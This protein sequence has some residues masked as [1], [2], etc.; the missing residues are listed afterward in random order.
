MRLKSIFGQISS[1]ISLYHFRLL[2][3]FDLK[4]PSSPFKDLDKFLK[5][6][7][8]ISF[9]LTV[10]HGK[11]ALEHVIR[12]QKT[13]DRK[14]T[15]KIN[16]FYSSQEN[17]LLVAPQGSIFGP[18][19]FKL[20]VHDIFLLLKTTYFAGYKDGSVPFLVGDDT[21][22]ALKPLE[23]IG[24]NLRKWFLNNRMKLNSGKISG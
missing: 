8:A 17:I 18:L 16:S 7:P 12:S 3:E 6:I 10:R 24:K 5:P 11:V 21:T 9:P 20:Y 13:T 4:K 19:F 15:G 22:D 14:Q 23:Q 2:Q 1:P